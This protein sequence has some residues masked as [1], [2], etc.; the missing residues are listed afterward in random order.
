M[1]RA[2]AALDFARDRF[3]TEIAYS[4]IIDHLRARHGSA[5]EATSCA[6]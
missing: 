5:M 1:D 3:S 6:A 4:E 2:V